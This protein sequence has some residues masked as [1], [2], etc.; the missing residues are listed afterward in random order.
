MLV[1]SLL[2]VVWCPEFCTLDE[3]RWRIMRCHI[4]RQIQVGFL[5]RVYSISPSLIPK[6][7]ED[8]ENGPKY[9]TDWSGSLE[10]PDVTL[11]D[12]ARTKCA[13]GR[14]RVR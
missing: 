5:T 8:T 6:A 13:L 2:P 10:R 11:D 7:S 3:H 4:S 1:K 14:S 9:Y 12:T